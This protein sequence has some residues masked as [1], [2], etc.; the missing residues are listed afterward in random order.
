[1]LLT[2]RLGTAITTPNAGL[3]AAVLIAAVPG[4]ATLTLTL[5]PTLILTLTL[6]LTLNQP[7]R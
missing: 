2:Y 6:T 3:A 4:W 5:T 1:M 7:L